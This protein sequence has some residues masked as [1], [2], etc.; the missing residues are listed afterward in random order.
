ML[1]AFGRYPTLSSAFQPR[2][3]IVCIVTLALFGVVATM[4]LPG[5]LVASNREASVSGR[6]VSQT[7]LD[8]IAVGTTSETDVLVRLGPPSSTT[9]LSDGGKLHTWSATT[10]E[11]S[12]GAVFLIFAGSSV[13]E[14]KRSVMISCKDG[15]VTQVNVK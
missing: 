2:S 4:V 8:A 14:T 10:R 7:E 1:G 12:S 11:T 5:C 15:V 9:Q 13:K 3:R 6:E